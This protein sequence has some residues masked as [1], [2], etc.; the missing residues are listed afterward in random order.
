MDPILSSALVG[1]SLRALDMA[2]ELWMA[3]GRSE[4]EWDK[5][6]EVQKA[7]GMARNP[8][9]LQPPPKEGV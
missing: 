9:Q 2:F 1:V 7:K 4:A 8:S 6:Y 5:Q 3:S